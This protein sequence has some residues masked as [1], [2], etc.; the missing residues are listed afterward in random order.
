ML[1]INGFIVCML[2]AAPIDHSHIMTMIYSIYNIQYEWGERVQMEGVYVLMRFLSIN[3]DQALIYD[4]RSIS[5]VF[6]SFG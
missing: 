2:Q 3:C 4:R 1:H 6:Y 5:A